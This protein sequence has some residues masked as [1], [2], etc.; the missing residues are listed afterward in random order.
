MPSGRPRPGRRCRA[1][2]TDSQPCKA[3]AM[4]G[5]FVCS[6]HGGALRKCVPPQLEGSQTPKRS[7]Q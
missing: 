6:A 2:R 3:Y 5:G 4:V 1:H 7:T